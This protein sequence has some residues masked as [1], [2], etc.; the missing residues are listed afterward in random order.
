ME[1]KEYVKYEMQYIH[2]LQ[3]IMENGY[4]QLNE[5][6]GVETLR[7]PHG[8]FQVDLQKE[9]P[10]L[11]IKHVRWK[12]ALKEILWIM[13]SQSN[14]VND[15]D[16]NI[17]DDWADPDGSIG[18]A[19]GYQVAKNV[20]TLDGRAYSSQVHYVLESLK[21][22][23]SNR[24]AVI[25]LWNVDD[26]GQMNLTPCCYSSCW[27][28]I[29]GKLNCMLV[30]RSADYL[31]GVPFNT[32]Q[33]AILTSLFARHL[34][35]R[36]GILTHV[37]S[38]VHIYCYESHINAANKILNY[39]YN[40]LSEAMNTDPILVISNID[41]NFFN[42]KVNDVQLSNYIYLADYKLDVAV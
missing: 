31:V 1:S 25:D 2:L 27:N 22:D 26:L 42:V 28:I 14:N 8:M 34:G 41:N 32:T 17:W 4:K 36:P 40:E 21:E 39:S 23:P 19:Y 16:A 20:T 13:Q 12:T 24:R 3:D 38:D 10:I 18:K 6:T 15:L 7:I 35:I 9:F 29:D 30:Q 5:R 33:Y 37:M 11:H